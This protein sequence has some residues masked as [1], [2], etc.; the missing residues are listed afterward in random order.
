MEPARTDP[1]PGATPD[2]SP[3][4]APV[5]PSRTPELIGAAAA[6]VIGLAA[7][8]GALGLGYWTRGP[9]PGFFPL[10]LGVLLVLL[11]VVWGVQAARGRNLHRSEPV[12]PG[13]RLAVALVLGALLVAILLLDVVGYQLSMSALVLFVLLIVGKRRWIESIVVALVAGFGIYALFANV[14]QVYLP[15]ASV[16]FL[17]QLGL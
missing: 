12:P 9:G 6:L 8:V 4:D 2:P 3:V 16:P 1:S 11:A 5:P 10:W 7:F 17:A 14:L 15:T 13:G